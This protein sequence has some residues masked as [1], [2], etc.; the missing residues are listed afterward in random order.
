MWVLLLGILLVFVLLDGGWVIVWGD[1]LGSVWAGGWADELE[2]VLVGGLA[3]ELGVVQSVQ[4]YR[5]EG[6]LE[7]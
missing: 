4:G 2:I 3:A 6:E 7:N 1:G 5:E